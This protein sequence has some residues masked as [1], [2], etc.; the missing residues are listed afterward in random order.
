VR[1]NVE[2]R[3]GDLRPEHSADQPHIFS[4]PRLTNGLTDV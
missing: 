1:R 2:E 4:C 3:P